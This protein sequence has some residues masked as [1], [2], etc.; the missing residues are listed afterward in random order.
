MRTQLLT[1]RRLLGM[2]IPDPLVRGVRPRLQFR[3]RQLQRRWPALTPM[4][5]LLSLIDPAYMA[6]RRAARRAS[7][8]GEAAGA[9]LPRRN[10]LFRLFL[11]NELG[12]I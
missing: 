4:L 8:N 9:G 2:D 12:K 11:R 1:A 3:R 5:T 6:A 10:S 7:H